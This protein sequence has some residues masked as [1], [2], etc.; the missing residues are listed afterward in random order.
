M[1]GEI[2]VAGFDSHLTYRKE[3]DDE[4]DHDDSGTFLVPGPAGRPGHGRKFRWLE[5]S[6]LRSR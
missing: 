6:D 5:N 4:Q 2:G 3:T 1:S